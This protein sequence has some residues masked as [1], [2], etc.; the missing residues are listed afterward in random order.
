MRQGPSALSRFRAADGGFRAA[1]ELLR[2]FRA[3]DCNHGRRMTR[4]SVFASGSRLLLREALG[5]RLKPRAKA[6]VHLAPGRLDRGE[7][8]MAKGA[9]F[10]AASKRNRSGR[11]GLRITES[12]AASGVPPDSSN[13]ARSAARRAAVLLFGVPFSRPPR[14]SPGRDPRPSFF[15]ACLAILLLCYFFRFSKR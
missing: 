12:S 11:A 10:L 1:W 2:R 3:G 15:T 6:D 14:R 13:S 5:G 7:L 4:R 9:A 8:R